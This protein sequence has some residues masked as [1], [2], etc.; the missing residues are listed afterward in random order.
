M[1][2][3]PFGTS[4]YG[5][6]TPTSVMADGQVVAQEFFSYIAIVAAKVQDIDEAYVSRRPETELHEKVLRTDQDLRSLSN[7]TPQN[8]WTLTSESRLV[9]HVLQYWYYYFTVRTHLQLALRH[10]SDSQHMYSYITCYQASR[11]VA[12]R[13][14]RLRELLPQA[15]FAGRVLDLQ[16]LTG[17][18]VLLF[19]SHR[20][21]VTPGLS[22]QEE[23]GPPSIQLVRR[24]IE[25]MEI[26]GSSATGMFAKQG[27]PALRALDSLLNNPGQTNSK[28]LTLSIPM[29]GKINISQHTNPEQLQGTVGNGVTQS[30]N[31]LPTW[32]TAVDGAE[33]QNLAGFTSNDML[34]WSM[35]LMMDDFVPFPEDPFASDQWLSFDS[36]N[37]VR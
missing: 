1:F 11:E 23:V 21:A 18:A 22:L 7:L 27:A 32:Q 14:V 30:A 15:F 37:N 17:G 25:M 8:W 35:D 33:A 34:S 4:A 19:T 24:V 9:D 13:Y 28:K 12:Q 26:V 6:P 29:L 20:Q 36:H 3:L 10:G 5:L 16:A 31:Q 2:N